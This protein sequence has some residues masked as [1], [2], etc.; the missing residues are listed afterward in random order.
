MA[1]SLE[2]APALDT[3]RHRV[4]LCREDLGPLGAFKWRGADTH[5]AHLASEG[6]R[7]VV[8]ASTGNFAAAV[9]W[10]A[11]RHGLLAEVVVPTDVSSA[12]YQRLLDLDANVHRHGANLAEAA[13]EA[14]RIAAESKL[15]FFEDGGSEWQL[16]GLATLGEALADRAFA[17]VVTPVACGALAGGVALGLKRAGATTE[18]VGVQPRACSRLAARFH[19][20]PDPPSRPQDTLAD[21]LADDRL[22]DPSFATCLELLRDI[23]VVDEA[24]LRRAMRALATVTGTMPEGAGAAALAGYRRFPGAVAPGDV[25][26]IVSGANLAPEIRAGVLAE[27]TD[28]LAPA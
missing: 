14:K 25:A 22:V 3:E 6:A 5:C 19:Q 8:A 24:D 11:K 26:I 21:G 2:R 27:G 7:G 13:E 10:A 18:V 9:A 23:L 20:R 15:A 12:K 28:E 1:T 4:W 17:A 16:E